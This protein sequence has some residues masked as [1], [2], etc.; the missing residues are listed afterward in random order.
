M[1]W[2]TAAIGAIGSIAKGIF[3]FKEEQAKIIS[4]TVAAASSIVVADQTYADAAARA[5]HSVYS[6]GP[7]VERLW[8]PAAMWIFLG[9]IVAR[10]FGYVPPGLDAV[11]VENVYRFFEIGLI[12]YL[13]L[14]SMDK[15]M[16]GF[17]IGSILKEFIRKKVV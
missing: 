12:G 4:E 3:G 5:I 16:K 14:R 2:I 11:E 17:Q 6:E 15:W 10:F 1:G 13:P 9:L 7:A 8:R